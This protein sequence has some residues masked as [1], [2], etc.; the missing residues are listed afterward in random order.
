M[1][2]NTIVKCLVSKSEYD[3]IKVRA[4]HYGYSNLAPFIRD[5]LLRRKIQ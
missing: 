4:E 2:R 5:T 3:L 1:V